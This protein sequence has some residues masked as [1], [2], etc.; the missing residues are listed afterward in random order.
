MA[1]LVPGLI[2]SFVKDPAVR[3]EDVAVKS[4]PKVPRDKP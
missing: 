3:V 2:A 4:K 1:R